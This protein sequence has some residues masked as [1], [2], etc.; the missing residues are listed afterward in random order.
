MMNSM[1]Q[2]KYLFALFV[3]L[4]AFAGCKG[5]SPTSPTTTP[6]TPGTGGGTGGGT[7]PPTGATITLSASTLTPVIGLS[8]VITATVTANGQ[9]VPNGT[10]VEFSTNLGTFTDTSA[11]TTIRTTTNGVATATLTANAAQTATVAA[12]VNNVRQTIQIAFQAQT[13]T[14]PIPNTTPTVGTIT[15]A[16]GRPQGGETITINGT[17]FRNPAR[18]VFEYP[19]GTTKDAKIVSLTPTQIVALTPSTDLGTGQQQA[20]S[21]TVYVEAGTANELKITTA[22]AFTYRAD[23]LT[24]RV[25]TVSPAS[26]STEGGTRVTIFGDGFQAPVQVFFGA[27]EAQ[28][29]TVN[30]DQIIVMSPNARDT[31]PAANVPVTGPVD[32]RI[33]NVNSATTI[34]APG[35]FRY[36]PG[37][38]ITA[39]GPTSGS[40][41]GGTF[42]TIDG[43]GF[44]DPIAVTVGGIA[45]QPIRVSGTQLL[46][47]TSPTPIPCSPP[48]GVISVTN[49]N[50]GTSATGPSFTYT[51]E[52]PL[53]TSVNP[54]TVQAGHTTTIRVVNPGVGADGTGTVRFTIGSGTNIATVFPAPAVITDP[55][56]PI[57]FVVTVPTNFTFPQTSCVSGSFTGTQ[58]QPLTTNVTFTNI[59]TGCT[60]TAAN[61]VT[62]TPTSSDCV[63]QPPPIV[64]V[65][66]ASFCTGNPVGTASVAANGT[67]SQ[68]VTVT[69]NGLGNARNLNVTSATVTG[70]NAGDF[71]VAPGGLSGIG[72]AGSAN[73]TVTFKPT[74]AGVRT[75]NL[76]LQTNDPATPTV[77]ICLQGTGTP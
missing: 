26:G 62:I 9:P 63:I 5:E 23:V 15:P 73:L 74:A 18:V 16:T 70:T 65:T 67:A 56:G 48:T 12:V 72:P 53:I 59:T 2:R 36:I 54:V 37:M 27:A 4:L 42:V 13:P 75:A 76:V 35:I 57:D 8:S 10:A 58:N 47:K 6:T 40:A 50:D 69:N 1:R 77:T 11:S 7:T 44:N 46:V 39:A 33:I 31:A 25:T 61:S 19:N 32:V 51:A 3:L 68:P 55:R 22:N 34:T 20:V 30:F 17:N 43:T 71:S 52:K 14:T 24:P 60:D 49:I 28:V 45:A 41:F 66:P 29:V 21:I 38:Q 64:S